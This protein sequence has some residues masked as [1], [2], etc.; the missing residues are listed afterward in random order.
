VDESHFACRSLAARLWD[1]LELP[2][3]S[4]L[5]KEAA[6]LG[7]SKFR[8]LDLGADKRRAKTITGKR[9]N[10]RR[11]NMSP[12]EN[13]QGEDDVEYVPVNEILGLADP[14]KLEGMTVEDL[15]EE[16]QNCSTYVWEILCHLEYV[17]TQIEKHGVVIKTPA[18][19]RRD[20]IEFAKAGGKAPDGLPTI[21]ASEVNEGLDLTVK[22]LDISQPKVY[23]RILRNLRRRALK[24]AEAMR[25]LTATMGLML[26]GQAIADHV[27]TMSLL[28]SLEESY[29]DQP[30]NP[31]KNSKT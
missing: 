14:L 30:S 31:D 29:N 15:F 28:E 16:A 11:S 9:A 23:V 7:R 4:Q 12:P 3:Q 10:E 13:S 17:I 18:Q 25:D 27:T 22:G 19:L 5:I 8:R 24:P 20:E 26:V 1:G 6:R 21:D 2:N